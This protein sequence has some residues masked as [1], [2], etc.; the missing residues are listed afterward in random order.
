MPKAQSE[1]GKLTQGHNRHRRRPT[2]YQTGRIS[3]LTPEVSKKICD[4][5]RAG[6]HLN[7]AARYGGVSY[8]TLMM[9]MD[10]GRKAKSRNGRDGIY[11]E[12]LEA[13]EEAEAGAEVAAVL[14]WRS[15]M[16]K[17]WKAA[18][19][20]LEVKYGERWAPK[21]DQ[22]GPN[23][24]FAG[25]NVNIGLGSS[26]NDPNGPQ[27]GPT[28]PLEQLLEDNPSLIASTMQVLDQFLPIE[29]ELDENGSYAQIPDSF[30]A[31]GSESQVIHAEE[32]SWRTIDA[33]R[34]ENDSNAQDFGSLEG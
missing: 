31:N 6:N 22:M 24:A 10:K 4:A 12:F 17:D 30:S 20:F 23:G 8:G 18:Q 26:A 13:V 21:P 5:I 27:S 16:P 2:A 15:A 11:L 9:W 25:V 28:A 7:V 29:G 14:H 3:M 19:K 34:D 33:D 1:V 32:G